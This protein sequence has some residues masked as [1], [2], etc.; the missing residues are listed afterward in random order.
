MSVFP[1]PQV[2]GFSNFVGSFAHD[3]HSVGFQPHFP[4]AYSLTAHHESGCFD[5]HPIISSFNAI[6]LLITV[7]FLR[8]STA[9]LMAIITV[10]GYFQIMLVSDPEDQPPYWEDVF[11]GL[12]AVLITAYWAYRVSFR[13]TLRAFVELPMDVAIWQGLGYWIGIESST[14]FAKLPIQRLGYGGLSASGVVTLILII[15]LVIIV[16]AIQGWQGRKYGMLQYY[17][18]W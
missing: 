13:R 18:F 8:P 17:L 16:V 1:I 10:L 15:I 9:V 6:C 3:L 7:L 4:G 14:I 5:L 2:F 12:P 11:G